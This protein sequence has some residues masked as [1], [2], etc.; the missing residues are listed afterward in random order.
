MLAVHKNSTGS[1]SPRRWS[2]SAGSLP[3]AQ[4][5][6]KLGHHRPRVPKQSRANTVFRTRALKRGPSLV[7]GTD[8]VNG[9]L[10]RGG[11]KFHRETKAPF[12]EVRSLSQFFVYPPL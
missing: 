9:R 3:T 6:F 1:A 7:A 8:F 5:G 4:L 12:A 2:R 11:V 10:G